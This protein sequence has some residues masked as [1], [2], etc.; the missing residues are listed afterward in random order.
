MLSSQLSQGIEVH[1]DYGDLPDIV[2][3]PGEINQVLLSILMNAIDAMNNEDTHSKEIFIRTWI[4]EDEQIHIGIKNTGPAI[5]SEIRPKIFDP[6]FTTKP[7]G[8]G[9]GLGLAIAYQTMQKHHG[10]IRISSE[11]SSGTEFVM[12]LPVNN[13]LPIQ[14]S[15]LTEVSLETSSDK[16]LTLNAAN[17]EEAA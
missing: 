16:T 12:D 3:N 13:E 11:D 15:T 8:Q 9:T 6:F 1:K 7:I 14:Q 4:S 5:P 10:N 2:C 17:G